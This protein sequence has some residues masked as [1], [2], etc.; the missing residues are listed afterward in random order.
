MTSALG[1]PPNQV[2][3]RDTDSGI[4]MIS[5]NPVTLGRSNL[6]YK[7]GRQTQPE[8]LISDAQSNSMILHSHLASSSHFQLGLDPD[9]LAKS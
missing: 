5:S 4:A 3:H 1:D 6:I 2:V 7:D 9:V 8:I